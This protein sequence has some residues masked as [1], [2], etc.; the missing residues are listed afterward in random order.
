MPKVTFD[1][2]TSKPYSEELKT[3]ILEWFRNISLIFFALFIALSKRYSPFS[4][5]DKTTPSTS[6]REYMLY[7]VVT[8]DETEV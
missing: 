1:S 6:A 2:S 3:I 8:R 7:E 5:M 4:A